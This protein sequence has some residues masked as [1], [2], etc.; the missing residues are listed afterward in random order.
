MYL[1]RQI[2]PL[3]SRLLKQFPAVLVTGARQVGKSTLLKH[4][5]KDYAY[6]TLDDPL[7]LEQAKQEPRLF[8]LNHAGNVILDEVQYAQE[9]FSLLKLEIDKQQKNGMFLL[10]GS[11]AFELMQNVSETLAGRIA[12]LKLQ[13]LSLREILNVEFY[14]PFIPSRDYL[15]SREKMLKSPENIWQIIHKGDMPRLYQQETDWEIYYSSYVSTYIERDVRQLTNIT[16]TTDFTRFMV[17][18]ASRSG[19]LLNYS[20]VA[21]EVGVS[22]ETIKRWTAILQTSGIIYLLQ[23]YSNNHL[24]RTIKTPKIY[25]LN[26]GLMAYLTKWLTPETI[27]KGAKSGQFFESFVVS[28]II[29][30]F[31]NNGIEPPLYFYRNTNHKEIDLIIEY[32]RTI[33]PIEIKTT[34]NPNKKMAKSFALLNSL[35]KESTI[36]LGVIINQYPNKHYLAEN[37][38]ALPVRYL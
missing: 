24:K 20:N 28:E 10:S 2:Q 21:Q 14:L 27:S 13:G 18:L 9:L 12:I 3:V 36:G 33:Y 5:A 15:A 35:G 25:F 22:N 30:S 8:F 16:N 34:A 6:L 4:I 29:K 26:T 32:N 31:T 23:P 7:L 17:A 19:E 11:Q 37:L 38:V 1:S